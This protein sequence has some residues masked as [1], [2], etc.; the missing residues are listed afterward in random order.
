M[1]EGGLGVGGRLGWNML[2]FRVIPAACMGTLEWG[3]GEREGG[4]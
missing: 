4:M 2:V 1:R 3:E